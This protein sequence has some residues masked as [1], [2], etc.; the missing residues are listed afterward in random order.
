MI[1]D[2]S[3][4]TFV[5][6][7]GGLG[8]SSV[9]R[10]PKH[11]RSV[12]RTGS[13]ILRCCVAHSEHWEFNPHHKASYGIAKIAA[14]TSYQHTCPDT[15]HVQKLPFTTC[16]ATGWTGIGIV[17]DTHVVPPPY[18]PSVVRITALERFQEAETKLV[19]GATRTISERSIRRTWAETWTSVSPLDMR[20]PT[21][22][23][24]LLGF[25][26][27]PDSSEQQLGSSVGVEASP[28]ENT[29]PTLLVTVPVAIRD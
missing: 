1:N 21:T 12:R 17:G 10:F 16:A 7:H 20:H 8:S 9:L 19:V 27:C 25:A 3:Q 26:L 6:H 13:T 2:Y 18:P 24:I 29:H 11:S 15:E 23:H 5:I 22:T 4:P 28:V 14:G